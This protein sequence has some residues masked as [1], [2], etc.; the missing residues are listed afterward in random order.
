MSVHC[1]PPDEKPIP[2][3]VAVLTYL[4][5]PPILGEGTATDS[6][7]D[8]QRRMWECHIRAGRRVLCSGRG[9]GNDGVNTLAAT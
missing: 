9:I 4:R 3:I 1:G 5:D 7:I 6:G 8:L 2:I